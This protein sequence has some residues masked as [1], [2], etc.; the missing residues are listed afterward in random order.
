MESSN[1]QGNEQGTV[2]TIINSKVYDINS[3]APNE[4]D[5]TQTT[6]EQR[7]GNEQ[8]TTN[9]ECKNERKE[10]DPS[11][12]SMPDAT[13]SKYCE[14]FEFMWKERPR[15]E[16]GDSKALAYKKCKAQIKKGATWRE[17]AE[18]LRRYF[19]YCKA[20]NKLHTEFVMQ[21]STFFG[22]NDHFREEWIVR[23]EVKP[24]Q[25]KVSPSEEFR[26]SLRGQGRE[27]N[28]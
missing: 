27:V 28:F 14:E 4:Q 17:L 18:G 19:S 24:E 8:V 26:Q 15:R 22:P 5:N 25:D 9:K 20:K 3:E 7:A 23:Q 12:A 6:S 13:K 21:M 10:K 16:G 1:V 11:Y 2:G